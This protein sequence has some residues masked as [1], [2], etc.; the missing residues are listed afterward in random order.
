MD[1]EGMG[2]GHA[3]YQKNEGREAGQKNILGAYYL[4]V[5]SFSVILNQQK[6]QK[7]CAPRHTLPR[8]LLLPA[9]LY[10]SALPYTISTPPPLLSPSTPHPLQSKHQI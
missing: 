9:V 4:P 8:V 6:T 3:L 10:L 1:E 5:F 2:I 7:Y